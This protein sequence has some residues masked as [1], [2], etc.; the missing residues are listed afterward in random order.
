[1]YAS[2]HFSRDLVISI[3]REIKDPNRRQK[4]IED[5]YRRFDARE[6]KFEGRIV[7]WMLSGKQ[8]V[9]F[10][11]TYK[12]EAEARL[13]VDMGSVRSFGKHK[14]T[15]VYKCPKCD[16]WHATSQGHQAGKRTV[17]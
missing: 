10:K 3:Q 5:L 1:M 6:I 11:K 17:H 12:T 2:D 7:G 14:A 4:K 8:F 13:I 16:G 15:E 9:C